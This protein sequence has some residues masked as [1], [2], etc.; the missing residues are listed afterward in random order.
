MGI[1]YPQEVRASEVRMSG[2]NTMKSRFQILIN[3]LCPAIR[4]GVITR[5]E[6]G[7]CTQRL[8]ECLPDPR[9]ELGTSIRHSVDGDAVNAEN[10]S[11]K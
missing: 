5:G 3:L 2:S 4:L 7:C 11:H 1:F 8:A 9:S 10:V 6:A